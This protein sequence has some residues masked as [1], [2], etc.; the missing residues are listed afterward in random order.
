FFAVCEAQNHYGIE[1]D[2][3]VGRL[4]WRALGTD[5]DY[6]QDAAVAL[7]DAEVPETAA[8]VGDYP[9]DLN[10]EEMVQQYDCA[11]RPTDL[12]TVVSCGCAA[13]GVT[14][15]GAVGLAARCTN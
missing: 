7:E 10:Q 1:E 13:P 8:D 15:S 3:F 14:D 6:D 4:T 5:Q 11:N 9:T 2:G 12:G